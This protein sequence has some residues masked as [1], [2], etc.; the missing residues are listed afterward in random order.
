[1]L[2]RPAVA[3]GDMTD[4]MWTADE[5]D[6]AY[7]VEEL[8]FTA[9][10]PLHE[11][12]DETAAQPTVEVVPQLTNRNAALRYGVPVLIGL[13]IIA[14]L[15]VLVTDVD[16][17]LCP[18]ARI[19]RE[20]LRPWAWFPLPGVLSCW[21]AVLR[22]LLLASRLDVG[23][24]LAGEPR[25]RVSI[26]GRDLCGRERLRDAPAGKPAVRHPQSCGNDIAWVG[27][28]AAQ[29]DEPLRGVAL[30]VLEL[31]AGHH[32]FLE[33]DRGGRQVHVKLLRRCGGLHHLGL[34]RLA[35]RVRVASREHGGTSPG[36]PPSAGSNLPQVP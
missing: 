9:R 5:P 31:L 15:A 6:G 34:L 27:T 23:R 10:A 14:L 8:A 28:V 7:G 30:Q 36:C 22:P 29:V 20:S 25:W 18:P 1:M 16:S 4:D 12:I 24:A 26:E 11:T 17:P 19:G 35:H 21:R 2:T 13:A 3:G 33:L 32:A